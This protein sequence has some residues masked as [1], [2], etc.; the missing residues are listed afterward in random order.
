MYVLCLNKLLYHS[1]LIYLAFFFEKE[2]IRNK[3]VLD[4]PQL[5]FSKELFIILHVRHLWIS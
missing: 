4:C 5:R 3:D 1:R 2:T